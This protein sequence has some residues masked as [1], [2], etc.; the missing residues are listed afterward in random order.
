MDDEGIS[1]DR[2]YYAETYDAAVPDWPGEISFYLDAAD[3][4]KTCGE[5]VL[6][7]ACGTGRV[8]LRLARAGAKVVGLDLSSAMLEAAR[9]KSVD[10]PNVS[11]VEADMR[12]FDLER[13][14]GLILIPGHAFHNLLTPDDQ[15]ACLSCVKRHLAP[16]GT[17]IVHLDHQDMAW[18]GDL[19]RAKGGV[20]E[21]EETFRRP[22]TGRAVR[23]MRAWRYER[24]TQTAI[25]ETRWEEL[26]EN[27]HVVESHETGPIR[28]HCLF[29][30][31]VE[32]LIARVGLEVRATYGDFFGEPLS[33]DSSQMIWVATKPQSVT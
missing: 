10:V 32:H 6:E 11:W 9:E 26:D 14:F 8:A 15:V 33:D 1:L 25:C 18:L 28:L 29:R 2:G 3:W 17:L 27:G 22:K 20:F 4:A 7:L 30:F 13:T 24:S 19:V 21:E 16:G 23:A 31:E 12:S 5:V